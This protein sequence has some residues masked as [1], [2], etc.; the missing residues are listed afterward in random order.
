MISVSIIIVTYNSAKEI[1]NCVNSIIPQI[2]NANG[3]I[4]IVDNNS[5][6][7][8]VS[9]LRNI[10]NKYVTVYFNN[11]NLGYTK[12]N[13]QGIEHSH[14]KYVLFLNP[15]TVTPNGVIQK[16]VNKAEKNN[17]IVIAPQ[18][19]FPD[20]SIQKSCRHFPRRRDIIYTMFGL[21]R[22]FPNSKEFNHWK[23]TDFSHNEKQ[24]VD[25]PASSALLIR[26][27]ILDKI[28]NFDEHFPTFFADV[29]ICKRIWDSGYKILFDPSIQIIHIGG[30]SLKRERTKMIVSSHISFF[31][32]FIKHK[33]GI[34][35]WV[36]NLLIGGL[37][38]LMIPIRLLINLLLPSL[39]YR[40]KQSL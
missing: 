29:D 30:A 28:G 21:Y 13:N 15:D 35:N 27:N 39:K 18:L 16:L 33:K 23:M 11:E 22:I 31:H 1:V 19:L 9:I 14:G 40:K 5:T 8:T 38:L 24:F 26:K 2:E 10:K 36:L 6:D 3:E 4:L 25:Q 37:L 7:N 32:Y 34:I 20:K 17:L 12:G